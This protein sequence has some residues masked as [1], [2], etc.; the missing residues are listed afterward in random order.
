MHIPMNSSVYLFDHL[1][2]RIIRMSCNCRSHILSNDQNV[3]FRISDLSNGQNV[4]F[5][6]SDLSKNKK[7][8]QPFKMNKAFK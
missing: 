6:S 8:P 4:N 5:R 1:I 3:N 2:A 7:K